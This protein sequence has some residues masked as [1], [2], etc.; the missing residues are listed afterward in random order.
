M[1]PTLRSFLLFSLVVMLAS[2][3]VRAEDVKLRENAVNLIERANALSLIGGFRDYEQ[4]VTFTFHDLLTGASKNGAF[5]RTSAGADGRRDE[6]TY[7]DY[8]AESV[9]AGDLMSSTR[10]RTESPEIV[11]LLDQLP[12]YLGHFDD[13]DNIRSIEDSN[14][15]GRA[16]KCI[17]FETYLGTGVQSN[18]I[19]V[20]QERGTLLRWRV[21]KELIENSEY[22]Q[23]A[24]LWEPGHIRHFVRGALRLE[25]DQRITRTSV[26]VD[27]SSFS[28][29]SG[30]WQKWWGCKN[31]RQPVG[32]SMPMPPPGTA[33]T[34][35]VNVVVRGYIW[36]T[37]AVEPTSIVSS[38][39][40]DLNEEAMKLVAT[41][42]FTPLMCN[43]QVAATIADFVVHFQ[44]R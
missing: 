21:G 29:P 6:F 20:D 32:T 40:P 23:V 35:I 26:P 5:T 14:V 17:N 39:R 30:K 10:S 3:S 16:A 24:R 15:L 8:R 33:G 31:R 43:D 27:V 41:W 9:Y 37:G 12:V 25:I 2:A 22:F 42:K 38:L 13:K 4:V 34:Q 19:C 11:E 28:P 1:A 44:G 18:Q 36:D 7:G